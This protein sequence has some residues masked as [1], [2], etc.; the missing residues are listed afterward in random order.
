ML[1]FLLQIMATGRASSESVRALENVWPNNALTR[2]LCMR[3]AES[4]GTSPPAHL[5][6]VL[7]EDA[8]KITT[9]IDAAL[10]ELNAT[11][12]I[13]M[14]AAM[15][16][17]G[18]K[19]T[20]VASATVLTGIGSRAIL[21]TIKAIETAGLMAKWPHNSLRLSAGTVAR[22]LKQID[23]DPVRSLLGPLRSRDH[24]TRM[25]ALLVIRALGMRQA[26]EHVVR[27]LDDPSVTVR[28]F[29]VRA[30]GGI[31][32]G[33]AINGLVEALSDPNR[34]VRAEALRQVLQHIC[35]SKAK[36]AV[37]KCQH[38]RSK[39]VREIAREATAPPDRPTPEPFSP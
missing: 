19:P 25:G 8:E 6:R 24:Q 5:P 31:P 35:R 18:R 23:P 33:P 1:T 37:K 2:T 16:V 32:G 39:L 22:V 7:G 3:I 11:G 13:N 30:L 29:A 12:Q 10:K 15:L 27:M 20:R 17:H 21:P 4:L 36:H 26:V 14:A 28:R 34:L 38:D 9:L